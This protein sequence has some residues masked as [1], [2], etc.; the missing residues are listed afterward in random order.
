LANIADRRTPQE[1]DEAL[2]SGR[3]FGPDRPDLSRHCDHSH[4]PAPRDLNSPNESHFLLAGRVAAWV[5]VRVI[6]MNHQRHHGGDSGE[7]E[8]EDSAVM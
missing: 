4:G 3:H 5:R 6:A 2:S 7:R 1:P 8:Y